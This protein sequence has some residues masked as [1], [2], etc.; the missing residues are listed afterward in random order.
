M[1]EYMMEHQDGL[2]ERIGGFSRRAK[3]MHVTGFSCDIADGNRLHGGIVADVSSHGF[4]MRQVSRWFQGDAHYY[5]TVLSGNGKH[6]RIIA[7]P[8]WRK[9][10]SDGLEI[11]FKIIDVSWEWTE[12]IMEFEKQESNWAAGNA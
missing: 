5:R 7:K 6:F 1:R 10:T 9:E 4:K 3:R 12:L 8:C 2:Q 11:G